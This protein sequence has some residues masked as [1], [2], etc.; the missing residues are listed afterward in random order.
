MSKHWQNGFFIFGLIVLALMVTQL[1]FAATWAGLQRAGY[2]AVAVIVLWAFLY[3]FNTAAWWLIVKSQE[4]Q[5]PNNNSAIAPLPKTTEDTSNT[6]DSKPTPFW[7]LY[8]VT[9]SGF[10]LNYATPGGLMGG[11]PYKIMMLKPKIGTERATSSVILHTMTHIFSHFWF[12]LLSC[13][14]YILTQPMTTLMWILL[15][16]IATFCL[17]AIWFFLKGYKRGITVWLMR[18]LS[19]FPLVKRWAQPFV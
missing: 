9:I 17:L 16:I 12:W 5:N 10:A 13:A 8:K 6:G 3:L 15:P 7:W 14:L 19:H 18:L 2:W 1:D 4:E 11:E